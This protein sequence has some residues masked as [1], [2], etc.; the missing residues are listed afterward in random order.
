MFYRLAVI[1]NGTFD[2]GDGVSL[3]IQME[4]EQERSLSTTVCMDCL[5]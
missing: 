2:Y 1:D 4:I 3:G 5:R